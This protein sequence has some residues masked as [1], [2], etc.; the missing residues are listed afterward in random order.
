MLTANVEIQRP[1]EAIRWNDGSERIASIAELL[2]GDCNSRRDGA[3][4]PIE[5]SKDVFLVQTFEEIAFFALEQELRDEVLEPPPSL[6]IGSFAEK[7]S[8]FTK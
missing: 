1:P 6:K 2:N 4:A 7:I 3:A 8:N 5:K